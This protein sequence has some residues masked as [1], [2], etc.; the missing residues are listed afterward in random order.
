MSLNRNVTVPPGSEDIVGKNRRMEI[1]QATT[2][3]EIE[4]LVAVHNA[5]HP[6][7]LI[8][9]AE[10]RSTES[11]VEEMVFLIAWEGDRAVAAGDTG[12]LFQQPE[13]F[14]HTWVLPDERRRGIGTAMYSWISEYARSKGKDV[15]EVWV[16]GS[17]PDGV[18]FV[19]KRGFTEIGREL[20][21]S[22]D[23]TTIEAPVVT[24]PEGITLTTWAERPDLIHGIYDVAVE[25]TPDI[26]G[27]EED[28]IEPFED[29]LAHEMA[30]GPGDRPDATFVALAGDEVVG[31]S[32]FSLS[33][34][35][36]TVAHHD[37]TG[38]KRAW[39][40]RGIARALKQAQIAWAKQN[41][42][43]RLET[44]NE[45]RNAPIRKLNA[46]FGYE[47]SGVRMLFRGPLSH[48]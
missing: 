18:D 13:P 33:D 30:A 32:K 3:A 38:V 21:V 10:M 2:D 25:A 46:D 22:L 42:F 12:L 26:P 35:Q 39:R 23:L 1:R 40:G 48:Q 5:V 14:A 36:P 16:E 47:P 41:G 37:L 43:E 45:E 11:Q 17:Q 15:L 34:A 27:D 24:A 44:R 8:G 29:W 6:N 20:R 4:T 7:D 19:R 9:L 31:Y 28:E